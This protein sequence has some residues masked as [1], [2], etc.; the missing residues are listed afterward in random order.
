MKYFNE[1]VQYER[2]NSTAAPPSY[3]SK[4]TAIFPLNNITALR[5]SIITYHY[6]GH[7]IIQG[8][9]IM[10][11][12]WHAELLSRNIPVFWGRNNYCE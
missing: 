7:I 1:E 5:S 10:R 3:G 9:M 11:I 6:H 12:A 4:V 8:H 2:Y